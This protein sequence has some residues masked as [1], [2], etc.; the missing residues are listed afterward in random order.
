MSFR[1]D[2]LQGIGIEP[3]ASGVVEITVHASP[4]HQGDPVFPQTVNLTNAVHTVRWHCTDLPR[5]TFLQIH[6]PADP[7]GPFVAVV[8]ASASTNPREVTGYGN[9]G[10]RKTLKEYDY[11]ARVVGARGAVKVVGRGRL[12]NKAT[13]VVRDPRAGGPGDPPIPDPVGK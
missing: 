11:E 8:E 1:N 3:G 13:K 12:N 5:G 6:F 4:K 9:R 10:P 7:L 2:D